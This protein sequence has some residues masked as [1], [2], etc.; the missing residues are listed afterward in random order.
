MKNA[1]GAVLS[2]LICAAARPVSLSIASPIIRRIAMSGP[3]EPDLSYPRLIVKAGVVVA[4]VAYVSGI[5]FATAH[6]RGLPRRRQALDAFLTALAVA[7]M[8]V[9]F[10]M[11]GGSANAPGDGGPNLMPFFIL[12][13]GGVITLPFVLWSFTA[14]LEPLPPPPRDPS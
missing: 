9:L 10:G 1:L 5:A 4:V 7:A 13:A 3:G 11:A 12:I 8:P 6:I 14:L 2:F